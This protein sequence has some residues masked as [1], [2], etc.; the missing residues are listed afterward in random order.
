VHVEPSTGGDV[1]GIKVVGLIVDTRKF[2]DGALERVTCGDGA[3]VTWGEGGVGGDTNPSEAMH[4]LV[5]T[6]HGDQVAT[7][8]PTMLPALVEIGRLRSL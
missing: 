2:G 6:T 5:P 8:G 4:P 3:L 1:V 7:S